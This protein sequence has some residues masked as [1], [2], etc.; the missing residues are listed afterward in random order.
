MNPED[1]LLKEEAAA[2][3]K[4]SPTRRDFVKTAAV[5][6]ASLAAGS[7]ISSRRSITA[8][9][10]S[11]RLIKVGWVSPKT[12]PI[13]GFAAADD[14][15]LAGVR[16]AIGDRVVVNGVSHPIEFIVKDSRSDPNR[17]AEVASSLIKSD[18]VDLIIAAMAPETTNPVADQAE[19]NGVPC[20]TSGTP[21]Q[22]YFFG[23]GGKPDK[24]FDWTYHFCWGIEDCIT[25]YLGMWN[26]IPTNRVVGALWGNDGDGNAFADP[27][28]G[29]KPAILKNGFKLI[30]PGRFDIM[31]NDFTA[32]ISTFKKAQVEILTGNLPPSAFATFLSQ[33]AQQGFKPKIDTMGKALLFPTTLDSLGELGHNLTCELWWNTH[34]PFRSSLTGQLPAE[35]AAQWE[36][37]TGKQFTQPI[38]FQHSLFEVTVDVLRR[39]KKIDSPESILEAIRTTNLDTIMSRIKFGQPVKNVCRTPLVGGQ[40]VR[41]RGKKFMYECLVV[42]NDNNKLISAQ[43]PMKPIVY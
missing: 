8:S 2:E 9:A 33:A 19:L 35:L 15:V 23:R 5:A 7:L 10:A 6:A 27:E 3:Q 36:A 42:N 13:A 28:R 41:T 40:W 43:A 34:F 11:P 12:G 22:A 39:T 21:W 32:Q 25:S 38:G 20:I 24:G 18:N 4:T 17:A 30:D 14:F 29:L 26:A 37:Q 16:K 31:T 1:K